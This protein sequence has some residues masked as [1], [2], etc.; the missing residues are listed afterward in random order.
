MKETMMAKTKNTTVRK[1]NTKKHSVVDSAVRNAAVLSDGCN[2]EFV[3]GAEFDGIFEMPIIKRPKKI[4]IP[5]KLVPFS[6][7]DQAEPKSFAVCEY[8]NDT[9][10]KDLLVNP[11]EYISILKKY[12]GFITP[13][14]SVYRDMPLA[15]Q[16]TN[17]YRSR[18]I[19]YC[20]QK[21][22]VY[23][24]P[25]VRWGDERTY[26]TK[27]LPERIAFLGIEKHSIVSVGSYGQL[28]NKVNRYYFEAGMDAMIEAL[29]PEIVLVYSQM[30]DAMKEKY[31]STIFIEYPD[32][33]NIVRKDKTGNGNGSE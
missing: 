1:K 16:I 8:E 21:H 31:P 30:P 29:E 11:D 19:G 4:I 12:Q 25:C 22:G 23:V 26:T 20:F 14:C 28:K 10:F 17:I 18:A 32:W 9:E 33:T 3:I 2:P 13:D 24:V 7:M 15:I 5:D 27:Y 6:K